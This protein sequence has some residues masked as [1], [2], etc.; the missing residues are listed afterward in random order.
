MSE[1]VLTDTGRLVLNPVPEADDFDFCNISEVVESVTFLP[2]DVE[3]IRL[4]SG[5]E[6]AKLKKISKSVA[7]IAR[8]NF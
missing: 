3:P 7:M 6:S 1:F 8:M 4:S 2:I 5:E